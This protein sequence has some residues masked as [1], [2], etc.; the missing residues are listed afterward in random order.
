MESFQL[1]VGT[2]DEDVSGCNDETYLGFGVYYMGTKQDWNNNPWDNPV[3]YPMFMLSQTE[4]PP[5]KP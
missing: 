4:G 3:L 2:E 1:N 5:L